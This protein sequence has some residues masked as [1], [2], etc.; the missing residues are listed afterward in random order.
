MLDVAF[1]AVGLF[2]FATELAPALSRLTPAEADSSAASE[3]AE[4]RLVGTAADNGELEA[5]A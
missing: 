5:A 3:Q 2:G 1:A 4:T